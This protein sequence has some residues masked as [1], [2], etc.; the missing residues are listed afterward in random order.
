M[1]DLRVNERAAAK[2]ATKLSIPAENATAISCERAPEAF[3]VRFLNS[4]FSA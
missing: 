3:V 4:S 1:D 2:K